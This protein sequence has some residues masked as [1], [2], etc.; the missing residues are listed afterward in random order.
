MWK[1]K[2]AIASFM[3]GR[4]GVDKLYWALIISWLVL[5]VINRFVGS[6][7]LYFAGLALILF[8]F[9]RFFSRNI[10]K[11][12]AENRGFIKFFASV[13]DWF[14]LL[15]SRFRDIGKK[16]YRKCKNCH[17]VLRLPIKRGTN[18]VRCPKCGSNIKVTII[19]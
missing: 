12:Q 1:I 15:S 4:Y 18:N 10:Y 17:A 2:Q 19:I 9:F 5:T 7:L 6:I 14:K 13:K 8:A 16:R 3:Y 11:R